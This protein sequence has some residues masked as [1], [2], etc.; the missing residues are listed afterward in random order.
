MKKQLV[1]FD[2]DNTLI[3]FYKCEWFA[4]DWMFHSFGLKLT[5]EIHNVFSEIDRSLWETGK[6]NNYQV[7]KEN[8]PSVRFEILFNHFKMEHID[9]TL[10]NDLFGEQ[11]LKAIFP[12]ND[13]H[14]I[15]EYLWNK[16]YIIYVATNGL[17]RLQVP[18]IL[19][20]SFGRYIEKII[21]SEEA[22]FSKPNPK[23]F[24]DILS[25]T[26][27]NNNQA[28]I[29]GDSLTN[30]ILGANNALIDSIWYNPNKLSNNSNIKPQYEINSLNEIKNIL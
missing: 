13:A 26:K 23:I 3:D 4:L 9:F 17:R 16:G 10:A 2:A 27:I 28:I 25:E 8:I 19:N 1:I 29:I 30:D 15:V 21:T 12:L 18:R 24:N 22:G 14:E 11:F 7:S 6:W 5:N 20:T